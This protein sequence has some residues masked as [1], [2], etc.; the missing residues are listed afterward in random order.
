MADTATR[1]GPAGEQ[2]GELAALRA[3][4]AA[5]RQRLDAFERILQ[6]R[7]AALAAGPSA[8]GAPAVSRPPAPVQAVPEPASPAPAV[9]AP[10][11]APAAPARPAAAPLALPDQFEIAADELLPVHDGFYRLEWGPEGAF[12]WTGPGPEVRFEA[13]VDRA[14][15]LV[16]TVQLFHFGVPANAKDLAVEVDGIAYPLARQGNG[17][18]LRSEPIAA[19]AKEGP[20]SLVLRVAHLHSPAARGGSDTR[21]LGVA[22]QRLRLERA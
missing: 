17:K 15:P 10:A 22:F 12:R 8:A 19:R 13:W 11:V 16:A 20:T 21:N 5:L 6:L 7:D 4:V 9:A 14:A 2:E 3:E 1:P 18:L